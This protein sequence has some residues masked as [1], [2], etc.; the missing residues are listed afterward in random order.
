M[1]HHI[2]YTRIITHVQATHGDS[3]YRAAT[4]KACPTA[5]LR[6]AQLAMADTGGRCI[7]LTASSPGA[8]FGKMRFRESASYYGGDA[9]LQLYG[10]LDTVLAQTKSKE[11]REALLQYK[12]LGEQCVKACVCVD[13]FVSSDGDKFKVRAVLRVFMCE[14]VCVYV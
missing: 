9:E 8:G 7:L 12:G 1:T 4:E 10:T 5:A 13:V 2:S 11:D 3:D 6:V 14:C